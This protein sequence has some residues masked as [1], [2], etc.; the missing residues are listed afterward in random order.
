M[1]GGGAW[2]GVSYADD[3][4]SVIVV[5]LGDIILTCALCFF[6]RPFTINTFFLI[7]S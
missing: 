7:R 2:T 1:S 4:A 5:G 6:Y 3:G